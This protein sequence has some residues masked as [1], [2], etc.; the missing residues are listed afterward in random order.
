MK[1]IILLVILAFQIMVK[2]QFSLT[3]NGFVSSKDNSKNY[4]LHLA[5]NRIS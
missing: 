4:D 1:K 2:A 3:I 5:A